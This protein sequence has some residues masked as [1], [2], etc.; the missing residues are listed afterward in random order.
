MLLP[1]CHPDGHGLAWARWL[2]SLDIPGKGPGDAGGG[3]MPL[4]DR[5]GRAGPKAAMFWGLCCLSP[6]CLPMR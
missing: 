3:S 2:W 6:K 4:A 1:G 5:T